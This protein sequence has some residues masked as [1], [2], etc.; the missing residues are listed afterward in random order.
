MM[1]PN[2]WESSGSGI[3]NKHYMFIVEGC[4]N[5]EPAR[6]FFN[7]FLNEALNEHRKVFEIVGNK[8][9]APYIT[10][11]LSGLGFSSTQKDSVLC[12]VGGSFNRVIKIIF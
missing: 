10:E 7:E 4:S 3:G 2:H 5:P 11:Q 1:S 8:M 9:K 12:R 6:G